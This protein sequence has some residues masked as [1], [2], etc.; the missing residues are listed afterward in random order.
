MNSNMITKHAKSTGLETEPEIS[1]P[2]LDQPVIAKLEY[3]REEKI[4]RLKEEANA[5]FR[6]LLENL[7]DIK[8]YTKGEVALML[9]INSSMLSRIRSGANRTI[10][11]I[12]TYADIL[13]LDMKR[14]IEKYRQIIHDHAQ[15][16]TEYIE[17]KR[18]RQI[19]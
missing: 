4:N 10:E 11:E 5:T 19:K 7:F 17:S 18:R 1:N 3:E 15:K 8:G 16:C 14:Y 6:R 2:W 9:G 12:A 13:M